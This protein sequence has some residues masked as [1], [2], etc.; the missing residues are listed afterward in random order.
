MGYLE[1]HTTDELKKIVHGFSYL[2]S[3][4]NLKLR[5]DMEMLIM[6]WILSSATYLTGQL[7]TRIPNRLWT[8]LNDVENDVDS[9]KILEYTE[10][11]S[12]TLMSLSV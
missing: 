8:M 11:V 4:M 9:L 5:T 2:I 1:Q 6:L 3:T 10:K 12:E 7:S